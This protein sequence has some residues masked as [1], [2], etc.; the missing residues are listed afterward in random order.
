MN[1]ST[2][3]TLHVESLG[4]GPP[5]VLLHSSGLSGR[6]WRRLASD[7]VAR[8]RAAILPDLTGHG[9][10]AP[11]PEPVPFSFLHD[12]EQIVALLAGL[13]RPADL[14]GHSYG[15][16]LALVAA[17]A[18]PGAVRSLVLF[19][20]VAF[21]AL[22]PSDAEALADLAR[23]SF[24]WEASDAGRERWVRGFVEYW[25]G[26]GAWVALR[27]DARAEFRRVAW[28]AREGA[29]TLSVDRTPA[30]A[31]RDLDVPVLLL[32]GERSP[33]A[34][35]RAVERLGEAIPGA[36]VTVI[37]DAGHMGPLTHAA[38][39]NDAALRALAPGEAVAP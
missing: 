23:V 10:S 22:D 29:K 9:A 17:R 34:A 33:V 21:G 28:V 12:V 5:V 15:G 26:D 7:L 1:A 14:V 30:A 38:A 20:P 25:G 3:S 39:V 24:D 4:S 16:F 31:Y 8:G 18:A 2:P 36:R 19:D 13:G 37:R 11:W 6:Q 32:G 27:E 35:R